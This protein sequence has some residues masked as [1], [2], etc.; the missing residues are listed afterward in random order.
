[1]SEKAHVIVG[2]AGHIDHGKSS[3]VK[4]L[5]GIDPDTLPEEKERGLTIELGFVFMDIPDYE[6]QIIFIDVP[7]HEKFVKT[8]VAGASH[9]DAVL[10][11]IAAD[12]GISVQTREHFDILQLLGVREGIVALTKSDLVEADRLEELVAEV[13]SFAAR[14]FLERAP[15][16]PVSSVTGAGLADIRKALMEAGGRVEKRAD[17]GIF[18]MPLDRV[19]VIHGFGTVIAGRVLSGTVGVGDQIEIMPE[20]IEAKIRGIQVH[21]EKRERSGIGLRTAL[22]LQDI[23]KELLRR[24]QCAAAPGTLVPAVRMDA[25]LRLLSDAPRELKTRDRIRLHTGTDETIARVV[26]LEKEKLRPGESMLVQF[27]LESPTTAVYRDRFIIRTFSPLFTVGGGTILD[28]SPARHRRF[29]TIALAGIRK[30]EESLEDAV[31]QFFAK[32]PGRSRTAGDAAMG[33]WQDQA[34]VEEA[35][36]KLVEFGRLKKIF[37]DREER[38]VLSAAWSALADKAPRAVKKYFAANPHRRFMPLADLQS[39]IGRDA[40]DPMFRALVEDLIA[41]QIIVRSEGG[42]TIPGFEA[43]LRAADQELAD[44]IEAVFRRAGYEPPLEEEVCRELDLPLNQFRKILGTLIQ[45]GKLVR[46][47]PK[48]IYHR[49]SFGKARAAVVDYLR[50]R[51][52]ITIAELKDILRVSRKYACAVLEYLDKIQMTRRS[53]DKHVLK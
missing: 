53:V 3:L 14:T 34:S 28:V 19:F 36:S 5:T 23:D 20:R 8:M 26:L 4:A 44:R 40:D 15:V 12:E 46:L 1:M 35:I 49:D 39:Q 11:V 21:K 42:V 16:I 43:H 10:F 2:T 51:K 27:V 50:L 7:G 45:Q 38:Y 13:R 25:R 52:A 31:E 18:R 47:D 6:K 37:Y 41:S 24:G 22:N 30:F 9:V 17:S 48:V 32:N 33:L 29:D